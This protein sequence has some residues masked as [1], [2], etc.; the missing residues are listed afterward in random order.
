[1]LRW[2][3][4]LARSVALRGLPEVH[5]AL[6][7]ALYVARPDE[8]MVAEEEWAKAVALDRR[9]EDPHWVRVWA[10][11]GPWMDVIG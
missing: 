9:Y 11:G 2:G 7:A 8:V 1:M 6:A 10:E 3:R 4:C 5:A